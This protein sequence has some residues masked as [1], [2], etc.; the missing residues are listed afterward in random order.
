M[1]IQ[2]RLFASCGEGEIEWTYEWDDASQPFPRITRVLC[3]N[4]HP[5]MWSRL[6]ATVKKN[7][8][9][10]TVVVAPEGTPANQLPSDGVAG[11]LDQNVPTGAAQRFELFINEGNGKPDGIDYKIRC[12]D[13]VR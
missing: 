7:S 2:T 1:A 11:T 12:G 5:T 4:A 8:R 9:V 13:D 6:T 3:V 10:L